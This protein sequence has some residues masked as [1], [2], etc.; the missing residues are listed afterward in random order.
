MEITSEVKAQLAEQKKQCVHCKLI[1][2]EMEGVEKV[3]SD[4]KTISMVDIFPIVKGH[5]TYMLKEHYPLPAYVSSEE[6]KHK[7]SLIPGLCSAIK[8]AIVRTGVNIYIAMG[9]AAGQQSSHFLLHLLPREKGDGFFKF[10]FKGKPENIL[11]EKSW[12][13]LSNNMPIMMNNHFKRNPSQW[14]VGKG[15]VPNYLEEIYNSCKVIYEDEKVLCILAEDSIAKGHLI[16]YSKTEEKYIEK[17]SQEDSAHL[18]FTASFA[19]TAVFEGLGAHGSNIVL[20]SGESDDNPEGRLEVHVIPRWQDDG[21][22]LAWESKQA[23]YDLDS[24]MKIK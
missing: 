19:S 16:I 17:I 21:L 20:K 15:D 24:I 18:F 22:K 1:S 9:G 10:L 3:F 11:E 8:K 14:H 7:F 2:G 5:C 4:D 6:F 12:K 13:M 23:S